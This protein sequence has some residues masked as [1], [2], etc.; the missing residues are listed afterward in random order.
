M[1]ALRTYHFVAKF[2][3]CEECW[4][5]STKS[6]Y[7]RAPESHPDWRIGESDLYGAVKSSAAAHFRVLMLLSYFMEFYGR[8]LEM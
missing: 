1:W 4:R 2:R 6:L 8:E 7:P 3:K 5:F